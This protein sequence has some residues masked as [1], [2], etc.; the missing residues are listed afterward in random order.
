MR[1]KEG[2]HIK[3]TG[4][5]VLE[6]FRN[7]CGFGR[8]QVDVGAEIEGVVEKILEDESEDEVQLQV[9]VLGLEDKA[10]F[11]DIMDVEEVNGESV[12]AS[13]GIKLFHK[14]DIKQ[15]IEQLGQQ[16]DEQQQAKRDAEYERSH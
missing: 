2:D 14:P 11:V 12:Y 7:S 4:Y 5:S 8:Q 1:I 10:H 9:R 3:A 6:P 15:L 13:L 16:A